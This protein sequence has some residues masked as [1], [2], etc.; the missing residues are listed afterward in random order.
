MFQATTLSSIII[1]TTITR[2]IILLTTTTKTTPLS[3]SLI[4]NHKNNDY[5]SK[6]YMDATLLIF[7][8]AFLISIF[9]NNQS[10]IVFLICSLVYTKYNINF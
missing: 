8:I 10:N 2:S 4:P 5:R 1:Y 9:T 7:F 6:I 3:K